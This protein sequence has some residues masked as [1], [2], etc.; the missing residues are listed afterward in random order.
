MPKD[1]KQKQTQYGDPD[2]IIKF[3][4]IKWRKRL[5][6]SVATEGWVRIEWAN[7]RYGQ[8]IPVNWEAQGFDIQYTALGYS[9]D[10]A[11]NLIVQRVIDLDIEWLIIIEDDVIVP[12][13]LFLKFSRY[14][15]KGE[16]PVV[17]GLYYIKGQPSD[18]LVFRGRGTG[19]Y[20]KWKVGDKV[21][22]DGLP[23]GCLLIHASILRWFYENAA[24]SYNVVTGEVVRRV[25]ETP[26][27]MLYDPE[28]GGYERQDGTQDL[29]FFDKVIEHDVLKKTGW[30][31]VARKKY[32]LLCD[33]SIFCKHVDRNTGRMYP[34]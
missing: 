8:I 9:I 15:N 33:T 3:N 25:F 7:A 21:W 12:N 10:D 13:D 24:E 11:Y 34:Y 30:S 32:P 26:K 28:R 19:A 2:S 22:C 1:K 16:Y 23:M 5:L 18:P 6:V 14:M 17:S 29:F 27:K 20:T 31:K 4:K